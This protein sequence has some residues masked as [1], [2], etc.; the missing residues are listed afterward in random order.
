MTTELRIR[1]VL[2]AP[3]SRVWRALTDPDALAQWFWP[4]ETYGTVAEADP[5]PG[6]KYRIDGQK[7]GIKATG[8]Y[9]TVDPPNR[10]VM[11][12]RWGDEPTET[13]VTIDLAESAEGTVL[14]LVHER[15]E[16]EQSRDEHAQGWSD[17]LDRLPARLAAD[18]PA[19]P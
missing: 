17:C 16:D 13:L 15:F 18:M 9:V 19:R 3:P 4:H 12:W 2:P 11:T 1:R 8:E 6:G 5:R 10:L 14:T 7:A